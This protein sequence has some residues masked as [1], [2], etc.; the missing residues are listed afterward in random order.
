MTNRV[1]GLGGQEALGPQRPLQ[2]AQS[3]LPLERLKPDDERADGDA[4]DDGCGPELE[5]LAGA[6]TA[7]EVGHY[8][9]AGRWCIFFG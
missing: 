7:P 8:R 9:Q 5:T 4:G 2:M 6:D 1:L 3:I